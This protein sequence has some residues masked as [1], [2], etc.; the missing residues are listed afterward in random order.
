[1][2][3]LVA[4]DWNG[5]LLADSSACAYAVNRVLERFGGSAVTLKECREAVS[6]PAV[7]F[8]VAH[9]CD[10]DAMLRNRSETGGIFHSAYES[11]ASGVRSRRGAKAALERLSE[12]GIDAIV[13]SNHL[14]GSIEAHLKRLG[15]GRYVSAVLANTERESFLRPGIKSRMLDGYMRSS[16][17]ASS[18][19]LVVGDSPE[20][21]GV[22][23]KMGAGSVAL[24]GGFYS[25]QRLRKSGPDRL[26]GSLYNLPPIVEGRA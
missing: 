9:G 26:L 22:A 23:K 7:E 20:D 13:L 18:E 21:V 15:M 8:Y 5:T 4:F 1:M 12:N 2:I 17:L 10:R 3:K 6:L 16:D 11:A 19:V 25:T 24:T 14:R